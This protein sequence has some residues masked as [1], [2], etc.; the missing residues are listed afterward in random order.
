MSSRARRGHPQEL[1]LARVAVRVT[2]TGKS[3]RLSGTA[4]VMALLLAGTFFGDDDH[5]PFGPFRM[6]STTNEL[7]GT[8]NTIRFRAVNAEGETV[9]PR[10]QDFGLRPAEI[11]GQVARIRRQPELLSRLAETYGRL[12]PDRPPLVEI[13][14]RYGLHQLSNGRP[15]AYSEEEVATWAR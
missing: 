7:D 4:L 13:E 8:V 15:I 10:S 12:H 11:N 2:S 6:Y 14:L 1:S 9:E 5:F 3:L